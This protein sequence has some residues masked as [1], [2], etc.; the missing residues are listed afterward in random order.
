MGPTGPSD[1]ISVGTGIIKQKMWRNQNMCLHHLMQL[2]KLKNFLRGRP[3]VGSITF[4][5]YFN[6]KIQIT[7]FKVIQI[8][9]MRPSSLGGGRILHRSL[10]VC[11]SVCLSVRP[12]RYHYRASCGVRHLANYNDT[13]VLFGWG[14]HVVRPSRPHKFL[15]QLLWLYRRA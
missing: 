6:Y 11:L 7:F 4:K 14:P 3:R 15:F 8:L 9:F 5:M 13:H 10:S 12:S 1:V 2:T